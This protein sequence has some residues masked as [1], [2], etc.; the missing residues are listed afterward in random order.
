MKYEGIKHK[1]LNSI[2]IMWHPERNNQL[3]DIDKVIFSDLFINKM[4]TVIL[5]AGVGSRLRPHTLEPK[6]A[7]LN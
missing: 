3:E 2:G 7:L 6:N 4:Q 1:E 5:A